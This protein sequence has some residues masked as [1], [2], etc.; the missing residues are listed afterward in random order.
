VEAVSAHR[1]TSLNY[2][3]KA[4]FVLSSKELNKRVL[5]LG[6]ESDFSKEAEASNLRIK[7]FW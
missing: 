7:L 1:K 3:I 6:L 2:L 5:S 4:Y